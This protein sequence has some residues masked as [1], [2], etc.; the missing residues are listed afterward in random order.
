MKR[1]LI[2]FKPDNKVSNKMLVGE[3]NDHQVVARRSG[4]RVMYA[5]CLDVAEA[6]KEL[7][8]LR[9]SDGI[10]ARVAMPDHVFT[11]VVNHFIT[12]NLR[13]GVRRIK[14]HDNAPA[15]RSALVK[16]VQEEN[17]RFATFRCDFWYIHTSYLAIG[18]AGSK[19]V[20]PTEALFTSV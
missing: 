20:V 15:H 10:V 1:C 4:K 16:A 13:F 18:V 11:A 12:K 2:F 5:P 19:T 9:V 17:W 6:W 7:C 14:F 3:N 8:T